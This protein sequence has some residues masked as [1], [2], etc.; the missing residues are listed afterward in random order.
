MRSH[1]APRRFVVER[2]D[3]VGCSARLERA[4][5]LEVLAFEKQRRA[6]GR[7]E[8]RTGQN[9]RAMDMRADAV[10]GNANSGEIDGHDQTLERASVPKRFPTVLRSVTGSSSAINFRNRS[11]KTAPRRVR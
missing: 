2:E 3:G 6:A 4:D 8:P 7:I 11:E 10:V 1:A 9:R 5:L